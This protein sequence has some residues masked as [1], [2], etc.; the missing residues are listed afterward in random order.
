M[1]KLIISDF[2]R[3]T[4]TLCFKIYMAFAA[5]YGIITVWA[6]YISLTNAQNRG[7]EV[8]FS[9]DGFAFGG[10]MALIFAAAVF[11]GMFVGREYSDGAIR[12]KLVVGHGRFGIYLS[13]F[14]VCAAANV[15]AL[16][17]NLTVVFALG[18]PLM[19]IDMPAGEAAVHVIISVIAVIALTAAYIFIAMLV[20]SK[21]SALVILFIF[22]FFMFMSTSFIDSRL[23]ESEYYGGMA[24]VATE[25]GGYEY[26]QVEREKNPYYPEGD[27]RKALEFLN[28]FLPTSQ[29]YRIASAGSPELAKTAIYDIIVLIAVTEAGILLFRKKDIK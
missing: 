9:I 22:A 28:D 8:S 4:K 24:L 11:N 12:N 26:R 10:I 25:D 21:T 16:L 23:K 17:L 2:S 5:I 19:G 18:I 3:M 6:E 29:L 13:D 27:V 1:G 7:I 20:K 14:L 15:A